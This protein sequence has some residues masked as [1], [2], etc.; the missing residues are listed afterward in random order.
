MESS[1]DSPIMRTRVLT[2]ARSGNVRLAPDRSGQRLDDGRV[3][4]ARQLHD[5]AG[6]LATLA[7][8]GPLGR[9]D[10]IQPLT[11]RRDG[12]WIMDLGLDGDDVG[13]VAYVRV[14]LH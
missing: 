10:Q 7:V 13:L 12:G 9:R 14:F 8:N 5:E 2:S 3:L 4:P 1:V 11:G 6:R